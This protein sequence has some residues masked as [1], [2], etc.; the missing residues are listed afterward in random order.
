MPVI[1]VDC[2]KK[3]LVGQYKN[4]GREY[5]P[6]GNP[7]KVDVHDFLGEAGKAIPYGVYDV[8]ANTGWVT[9]GVDHDTAAFAVDTM[10]P[11][12]NTRRPHRL[13][14]RRPVADHR[15]QWWLQRLPAPHLEDRARRARRRDRPDDHRL[16]PATGHQQVES[17]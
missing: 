6:A 4:G 1:S 5:R 17:R 16:P 7:E 3:E 9:V 8:G 11:W 12:W 14:A 13:P 2:K 10:R 15:R